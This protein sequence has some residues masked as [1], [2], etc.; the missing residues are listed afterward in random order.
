[1]VNITVMK[2]R[3]ESFMNKPHVG[4]KETGI[5]TCDWEYP[6]QTCELVQSD[7]PSLPC[8]ALSSLVWCL[9]ENNVRLRW[10]KMRKHWVRRRKRWELWIVNIYPSY[11]VRWRHNERGRRSGASS[12]VHWRQRRWALKTKIKTLC[13]AC[14]Y[15]LQ[16]SLCT[17]GFLKTGPT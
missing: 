10:E 3:D 6:L 8:P 17:N 9:K 11:M 15:S 7:S 14:G 12:S 5:C 13:C 16:I 1:M 4:P 2:K